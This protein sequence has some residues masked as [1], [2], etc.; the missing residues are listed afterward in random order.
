MSVCDGGCSRPIVNQ[1]DVSCAFRFSPVLISL[2]FVSSLH[3][4]EREIRSAGNSIL[5]YSPVEKSVVF[6]VCVE[7]LL[8]VPLLRSHY[9]FQERERER[10]FNRGLLF[11]FVHAL[12]CLHFCECPDRAFSLFSSL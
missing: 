10:W 3:R 4:Q 6:L 8:F 9:M 2:S 1:C 11:R 5:L 7:P 12:K